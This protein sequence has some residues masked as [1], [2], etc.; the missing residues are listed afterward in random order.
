MGTE[1]VHYATPF[2]TA[3]ELKSF[4]PRMGTETKNSLKLTKSV[5]LLKSFKPRMGTETIQAS[6][7]QLKSFN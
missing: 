5:G 2:S 3:L 4:K 6:N 7:L 1:T